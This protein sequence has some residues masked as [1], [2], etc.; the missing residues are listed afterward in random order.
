MLQRQDSHISGLFTNHHLHS[1]S[2]FMKK[3]DKNEKRFLPSYLND[4]VKISHLFVSHCT[5]IIGFQYP[6]LLTIAWPINSNYILWRWDS[7]LSVLVY[8]Y[9][10]RF[11]KNSSSRI[12]TI[13]S[14]LSLFS[15]SWDRPTQKRF[16]V[17]LKIISV[18][19]VNIANIF[20]ISYRMEGIVTSGRRS[21]R[22]N[23]ENFRYF[24]LVPFIEWV[25]NSAGGNFDFSIQWVKCERMSSNLI[26]SLMWIRGY[27]N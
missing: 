11:N 3:T 22:T 17:L 18:R 16:Y 25:N 2:I 10:N 6:A 7:R 9:T 20:W 8:H 19:P 21:I 27:L 23:V 15:I 24:K 1:S 5:I 26:W 12:P 14:F 4:C 13:F